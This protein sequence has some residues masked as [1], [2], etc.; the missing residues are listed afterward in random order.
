MT[1]SR[2]ARS[3]GASVT[4]QLNA[5]AARLRAAGEPVIHL[6]GGEPKSHAPEAAIE[7][8]KAMLDTGEIRYTPAAGTPAMRDA[9]IAYTEKYYDR[10]VERTN[11][12]ASAG[13]KQSIMVALL[14]LIDPGDEVVYPVPYWVSYPEMVKLAGGVS[15]P[16]TPGDGSFQPTVDEMIPPSLPRPRPSSS[17]A[18]ATPRARSSTGTSCVLSSPT[19]RR[20]GSTSSST[21]SIT[22]WFSTGG[23]SFTAN[24]GA[25]KP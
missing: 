24:R 19:A 1:F 7:A 8:G 15:V 12:I 6:G 25:G 5:E 22:V 2:A 4:L 3:I 11:V 16:V 10:R 9:V 21:T 13:V 23:N 20:R 14:A 17:T 18:R